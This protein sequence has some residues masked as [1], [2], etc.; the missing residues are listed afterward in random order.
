MPEH[1]D[2]A[3][4]GFALAVYNGDGVSK[5][6]VS[7]Q[8]RRGVDVNLLLFAAYVSV[9][10]THVLTSNDIAL[11]QRRT[12][13]WQSEVVA[14]LRAVRRRLKQDPAAAAL[15]ATVHDAELAAEMLEL[16]VLA[17]LARQFGDAPPAAPSAA[18]VAAALGAVLRVGDDT[19][20]SDDDR[21]D[22]A[23]I[24]TAAARA[25]VR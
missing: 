4:A 9:R 12:A 19:A 2:G 6:A 21:R 25:G 11:A 23:V 13:P 18:V 7:L 5:A 3:F 24:A 10:S 14:P 22:I 8:D 1:G 16:D 17:D 15:R 20:L